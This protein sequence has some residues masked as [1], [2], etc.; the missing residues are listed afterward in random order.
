[1]AAGAG[2]QVPNVLGLTETAAVTAL[3]AAGLGHSVTRVQD[4]SN[5]GKIVDESPSGGTLTPSSTTVRL[6]LDTG[7]IKT[8]GF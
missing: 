1:V 3:D 5:P 2:V 7:T 4:C 6:T 8:Y